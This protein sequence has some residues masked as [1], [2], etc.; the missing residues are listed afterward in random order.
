MASHFF[1]IR[2]REAGLVLDIEGGGGAGT[3]VVLWEET[4][5]DHQLWYNC[6]IDE[7]VIRSKANGCCLSADGEYILHQAKEIHLFIAN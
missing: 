4:G 2:A 5:E 3:P 1:M 6:P 7:G